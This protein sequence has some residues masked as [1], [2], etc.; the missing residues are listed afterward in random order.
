MWTGGHVPLR[1]VNVIC[2]DLDPLTFILHFTSELCTASKLVCSLL[3]AVA[4]SLSVAIKHFPVCVK[5]LAK[6]HHCSYARI[7]DSSSAYSQS[8]WNSYVTY[9]SLLWA[10]Y[11]LLV[12]TII[13]IIKSRRMRWVRHVTQMGE[14]RNAYRLL[15]WKR[16]L[17]RPM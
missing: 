3:E 2:V 1:V 13:R 14:K 8:F 16:P 6:L 10:S 9:L 7:R 4:G 5:W 17:G 12:P 11:F 15:V